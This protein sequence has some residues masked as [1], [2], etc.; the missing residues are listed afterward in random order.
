MIGEVAT[1]PFA[2]RQAAGDWIASMADWRWYATLTFDR[3]VSRAHA[4]GTLKK[5]SRWVAREHVGAHVR[6]AFAMETTNGAGI[7]HFH[8]LLDALDERLTDVPSRVLNPR[9]AEWQWMHS[10]YAGGFT[11]FELYQPSGGAAYYLTKTA[12]YDVGIVCPR[13]EARCRR[14]GG[15][16][17]GPS[18]F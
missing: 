11:R 8:L 2:L 15:C 17:V 18:P 16:R 14:E 3:F 12:S 4:L 5:W 7:W 9:V 10:S 13:F 6:L 1:Q